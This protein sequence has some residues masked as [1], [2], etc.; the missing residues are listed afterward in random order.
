MGGP[1]A[2]LTVSKMA[3]KGPSLL[4]NHSGSAVGG[5]NPGDQED[6]G[7]EEKGLGNIGTTEHEC[8]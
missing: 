1:Q 2:R 6:K 7:F 5:V 3:G 4:S 8:I